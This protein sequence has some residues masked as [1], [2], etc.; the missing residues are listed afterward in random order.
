MLLVASCICGAL[1]APSCATMLADSS[2]ATT[3]YPF[4]PFVACLNASGI[5]TT[6]AQEFVALLKEDAKLTSLGPAEQAAY[7]RIQAL[8]VTTD[9]SMWQLYV[10]MK[11]A[12][13]LAKDKHFVIGGTPSFQSMFEIRLFSLGMRNTSGS[14]GMELFISNY[15]SR[16]TIDSYR[17]FSGLSGETN[18]I[19]TYETI[20]AAAGKT[21]QTINGVNALTWARGYASLQ[22]L[23][24]I[25]ASMNVVVANQFMVNLYN[26]PDLSSA[27]ETFAFA[28]G[29]SFTALRVVMK[30]PVQGSVA[31]CDVKLTTSSGSTAG[32]RRQDGAAASPGAPASNEHS[33]DRG[34]TLSVPNPA[35]VPAALQHVAMAP[36]PVITAAELHEAIAGAVGTPAARRQADGTPLGAQPVAA[37]QVRFNAT[38]AD[39]GSATVR[40]AGGRWIAVLQIATFL[41]AALQATSASVS[42]LGPYFDMIDDLMT[43]SAGVTTELVM[44]LSGN[45][46]GFVA[47]GELVVRALDPAYNLQWAKNADGT[48]AGAEPNL[49]NISNKNTFWVRSYLRQDVQ[50]GPMQKFY[51]TLLNSS[52][53]Y[54]TSGIATP[55]NWWFPVGVTRDGY[56]DPFQRPSLFTATTSAPSPFRKVV[57]V[58]DGLCGSTC[59]QVIERFARFGITNA[60]L[61]F[62]TFGGDTSNTRFQSGA[63]CG[64]SVQQLSCTL[65]GINMTRHPFLTGA[66]ISDDFD[67]NFV[68]TVWFESTTDTTP[69]QS[70][71]KAIASRIIRNWD[72][73]IGNDRAAHETRLG[74]LYSTGDS[75]SADHHAVWATTVALVLALCL[76]VM[77]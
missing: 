32:D 65:K 33:N 18:S 20:A 38:R 56:T 77:W 9:Q 73:T 61:E 45:S 35:A 39:Y 15:Q 17:Q 6:R 1:G 70:E 11:R 66:T 31:R 48:T 24:S 60:Q 19:P 3:P 57:I 14:A 53:I 59:C 40:S 34:G 4:Q 46:G 74:L 55:P 41:P 12:I 2:T 52:F 71:P 28:D 72:G 10:S 50:Q 64:G 47:L 76:L 44:D 5:N 54:N 58:T 67:A 49:L 27:A 36:Q 29:S 21:I 69:V 30:L 51:P 37:G 13:E 75:S 22:G 62:V 25:H 68:D 42:D 63:F 43:A 7:D 23:E 16:A 8:N 26:V